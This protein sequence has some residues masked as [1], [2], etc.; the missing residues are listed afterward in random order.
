MIMIKKAK[1]NNVSH[2]RKLKF[3]DWKNVLEANQLEKEIKHLAKK[4]AW[5]R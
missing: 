4:Q 3:E 5:Y 1:D 2:K